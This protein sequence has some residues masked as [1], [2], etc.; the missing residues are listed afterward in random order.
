[1]CSNFDYV[2]SIIL[3]GYCFDIFFIKKVQF[4]KKVRIKNVLFILAYFF[5]SYIYSSYRVC[6]L[7]TVGVYRVSIGNWLSSDQTSTPVKFWSKIDRSPTDS[8]FGWIALRIQLESEHDPVAIRLE[9]GR[10]RMVLIP[11]WFR[12]YVIVPDA[13]EIDHQLTTDGKETATVRT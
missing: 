12:G 3:A 1:M 6:D 11:L 13:K 9:F 10:D 8:E 5:L 4:L 2:K 7:N